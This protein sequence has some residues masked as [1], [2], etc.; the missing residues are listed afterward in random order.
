MTSTRDERNDV[1]ASYI[2]GGGGVAVDVRRVA[3]TVFSLLILILAALVLILTVAAAR[4]N[5]RLNSLRQHGVSV[6]ATV[7]SCLGNASGTGITATG[8]TCRASFTLGDRTYID[9]LGGSSRLYSPGDQVR[10][11]TLASRPTSLSAA[12][13]VAAAP[14]AWK[15]YLTPAILFL[16]LLIG[17]ASAWVWMRRNPVSV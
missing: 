11:V 8:F 5:S 7:V 17:T 3:F 10:G 6:N 15:A 9:V 4:D 14:A 2:R 1:D 16:A 12:E 13:T